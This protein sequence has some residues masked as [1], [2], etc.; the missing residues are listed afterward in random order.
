[1]KCINGS[2]SFT[3]KEPSPKGVGFCARNENIGTVKKGGDGKMWVVKTTSKG[4]KRWTKV[5]S[6]TKPVKQ[7]KASPKQRKPRKPKFGLGSRHGYGPRGGYTRYMKV[8]H[9]PTR[10]TLHTRPG[11]YNTLSPYYHRYYHPY[12]YTSKY[13]K[14]GQRTHIYH[15]PNYV[16]YLH[17]KK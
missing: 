3:G 17:Y 16:N 14:V 10:P 6:A 7:K 8:Y 11:L 1:M 9:D 2:G 12:G 4:V 5:K 15:T 13:N